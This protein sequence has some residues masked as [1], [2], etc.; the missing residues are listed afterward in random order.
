MGIPN[1]TFIPWAQREHS[2]FHKAGLA[3]INS[4]WLNSS[5]CKC[6][7]TQLT[8]LHAPPA[9]NSEVHDPERMKYF[10][11]AVQAS[12]SLSWER[13]INWWHSFP[14]LELLKVHN[15][16]S[17]MQYIYVFKRMKN[18]TDNPMHLQLCKHFRQDR[19][20]IWYNFFLL[21]M[22][23]CLTYLSENSTN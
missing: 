4:Q 20:N 12:P 11:Q 7:S 22:Q 19:S 2:S 15:T 23:T 16:Y 18:A 1:W 14:L 9:N 5:Y 6:A 17:W 3:A 10:N 13:G 21:W 8:S